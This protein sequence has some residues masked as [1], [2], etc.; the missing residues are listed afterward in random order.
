MYMRRGRPKSSEIS[1]FPLSLTKFEN[2]IDF[3]IESVFNEYDMRIIV[4]YVPYSIVNV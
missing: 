3:I 2:P 1:Q 4:V